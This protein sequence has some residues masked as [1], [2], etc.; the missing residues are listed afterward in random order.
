MCLVPHPAS[1]GFR[2]VPGDGPDL[3]HTVHNVHSS[4]VIQGTQ[5]CHSVHIRL[6][7]HH[8]RLCPFVGPGGSSEAPILPRTITIH[9]GLL[10]LTYRHTL[11][12]ARSAVHTAHH[13]LRPRASGRIVVVCLYLYSRWTDRLGVLLEDGRKH[14]LKNIARLAFCL[15]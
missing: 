7:L 3:F 15:D 13:L 2:H 6:G 12:C 8:P 1:D 4:V 5:I 14:R 10:R 11:L 9:L